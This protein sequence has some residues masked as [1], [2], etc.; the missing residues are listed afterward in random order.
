M[1]STQTR[2]RLLPLLAL[3][4]LACL[5]GMAGVKADPARH[6]AKEDTYTITSV[7]RVLP[8]ADPAAMS[9]DFQDVRVLA[10]DKDSATVEVTYYPLY[11]QPVGEDPDWRKD[12]AGMTAFLHPTPAE[13]WDA[14]MRRDLVAQLRQDGIDPNTLTDKALVEQVSRW[15]MHRAH[16]TNAFAV[17]DVYYPNGKPAVFPALRAAFDAEK[18]APTWT[19]QQMF[20]QEALGK[21]M[22][23]GKVH[24]S[25]TSSSI[26][27]TTIFRALGIPTRTVLCIPPFDPNDDAQATKFYAAIHH[28]AV[29]E[30]VRAALAGA[31]LNSDGTHTNKFD[32]HLFNEVYVGHHWVRL[33]YDRL[34]QPILDRDYYGLLT[35]IATSADLS[36]T[37]LAQTWGLRYAGDAPDQPKLSSVN[38]YMLLSVRDHF[39]SNARLDNPAIPVAE[40]RTATITGLFPKGSPALP[41][42]ASDNFAGVMGD[43]F[44]LSFR[45][46][47]PGSY[48]QMRVFRTR[49]GHN[50]LLTAPGQPDVRVRLGDAQISAGDGSFQAF[51]AQIVPEDKAKLVPG[52]AYTLTPQN[53]SDTYRW[54][55]TPG[56]TLTLPAK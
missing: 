11:Q 10:R 53:T 16:T 44:L 13:N 38:P 50:F 6:P 52:V 42:F 17:W 36:K 7:L 41:Q 37:P 33:N 32:N 46:W 54:A 31:D 25:C 22:F 43:D 12:D 47:A 51:A 15:A 35:H 23:Y 14:A 49:V 28:N 5:P 4:P 9:D 26:Y 40:L 34:G 56:V 8:P 45:E 29:R 27:L 19:D 20:D 3:A 1:I 30:T 2:R 21:S 55:V 24:G 18:P 48:V 39:G